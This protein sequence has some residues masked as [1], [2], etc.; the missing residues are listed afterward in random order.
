MR[1]KR[2]NLLIAQM[3]GWFGGTSNVKPD[4]QAIAQMEQQI[5]MMDTVFMQYDNK[6][7]EFG[8]VYPVKFR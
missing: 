7:V 1:F 3:A 5:E 8:G 2:E 6:C 4:P